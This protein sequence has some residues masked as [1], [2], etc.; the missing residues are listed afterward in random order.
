MHQPSINLLEGVKSWLWSW[1]V[2]F[3]CLA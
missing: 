1:W 2:A 3:H